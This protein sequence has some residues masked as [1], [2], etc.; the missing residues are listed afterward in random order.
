MPPAAQDV[1]FDPRSTALDWRVATGLLLLGNVVGLILTHRMAIS[2]ALARSATPSFFKTLWFKVGFPVLDTTSAVATSTANH[3]AHLRDNPVWEW[4]HSQWQSRGHNIV[5][6]GSPPIIELEPVKV[7]L[8]F[9]PDAQISSFPWTSVDLQHPTQ[10]ILTYGLPSVVTNAAVSPTVGPTPSSTAYAFNDDDVDLEFGSAA[11]RLGD[12]LKGFLLMCA[13][14]VRSLRNKA[15]RSFRVGRGATVFEYGELT[16]GF[17]LLHSSTTLPF[18]LTLLRVIYA[19]S[20]RIVAQILLPILEPFVRYLRAVLEPPAPPAR[21]VVAPNLPVAAPVSPPALATTQPVPTPVPSQT[22]TPEVAIEPS[23]HASKDRTA[24]INSFK[25]NKIER[26]MSEPT[27]FR[28]EL[29]EAPRPSSTSF[30][31]LAASPKSPPAPLIALL[32]AREQAEEKALA[33]DTPLPSSSTL[34]M[35]ET[36]PPPAKSRYDFTLSHVSLNTFTLG[37]PPAPKAKRPS[38]S[39][40]ACHTSDSEPGATTSPTREASSSTPS[41]TAPGETV[42]A[43]A[44]VAPP[45]SPYVPWDKR[46]SNQKMRDDIPPWFMAPHPDSAQL[47]AVRGNSMSGDLYF[48]ACLWNDAEP[49]EMIDPN[50]RPTA[51]RQKKGRSAPLTQNKDSKPEPS[52]SRSKKGFTFDPSL[53]SVPAPPINSKADVPKERAKVPEIKPFDFRVPVSSDFLAAPPQQYTRARSDLPFRF[54]SPS[55]LAPQV[56]HSN[57]EGETITSS[58]SSPAPDILSSSPPFAFDSVSPRPTQSGIRRAPGGGPDLST[59]GVPSRECFEF[60]GVHQDS[61]NACDETASGDA[62]S[63]QGPFV[64]IR[65]LWQLE[66]GDDV[67]DNFTFD[68]GDFSFPSTPIDFGGPEQSD[69][70]PQA[71]GDRSQPAREDIGFSSDLMT[72][73]VNR[74]F[75]EQ[76]FVSEVIV[77]RIQLLLVR[78]NATIGFLGDRCDSAR[79]WDSLPKDLWDEFYEV[80]DAAHRISV[81]LSVFYQHGNVEI[82]MV[83]MN[84]RPSHVP[85]PPLSPVTER[86]P[87]QPGPQSSGTGSVDCRTTDE[88]EQRSASDPRIL[89]LEV[90]NPFYMAESAP[91]EIK[92]PDGTYEERPSHFKIVLSPITSTFPVEHGENIPPSPSKIAAEGSSQPKSGSAV[93]KMPSTPLQTQGSLEEELVTPENTK[94]DDPVSIRHSPPDVDA[95]CSPSPAVSRDLAFLLNTSKESLST[96]VPSAPPLEPFFSP[97]RLL[98]PS[99]TSHSTSPINRKNIECPHA[100]DDSCISLA[101]SPTVTPRPRSAS[102]GATHIS[103]APEPVAPACHAPSNDNCETAPV[104]AVHDDTAL[105]DVQLEDDDELDEVEQMLA[106]LSIVSPVVSSPGEKAHPASLLPSFP[107]PPKTAVPPASKH[108]SPRYASAKSAIQAIISPTKSKFTFAQSAGEIEPPATAVH[109]GKSASVDDGSPTSPCHCSI[110]ERAGSSESRQDE[111]E[112]PGRSY[113]VPMYFDWPEASASASSSSSRAHPASSDNVPFK[114]FDSSSS[115]VNT[116]GA[117]QFGDVPGASET[118]KLHGWSD[119]E[120]KEVKP[121]G[122][123]KGKEGADKWSHTSQPTGPRVTQPRMWAGPILSAKPKRDAPDSDLSMTE[124]K[125]SSTDW[126]ARINS[127]KTQAKPRSGSEAAKSS[128]TH[129]PHPQ[130]FSKPRVSAASPPSSATPAPAKPDDPRTSPSSTATRKT[131]ASAAN[132]IGSIPDWAS[133]PP[134]QSR[135]QGWTTVG[136]KSRSKR[137]R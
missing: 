126:L 135:N 67:P 134:V 16:R 57:S 64:E 128:S 103:S 35:I 104:I 132:A 110:C 7:I 88:D 4:L 123:G 46:G 105:S 84:K 106:G 108:T 28:D 1:G 23:S 22:H 60:L 8:E 21:V 89:V 32:N 11:S 109:Q 9:I 41:D 70:A 115:N 73:M 36:Y 97:H 98:H 92:L 62:S 112:D 85:P 117:A 29:R 125:G 31:D 14:I 95:D 101:R 74:S 102:V 52:I 124:L 122:K 53:F 137:R 19:A 58:F 113:F 61:P 15:K 71:V 55:Q 65:E 54:D 114:V 77:E 91:I 119:S 18:L 75:E 129:I 49:A 43:P 87:V 12:Y 83:S 34:P 27:L 17:S 130:S 111:L 37:A 100:S 44:Y 13:A 40:N 127:F 48:G 121:I 26:T 94:R 68:L 93:R 96:S 80:Y 120:E 10:V 45:I 3:V 59:S 82:D 47:P 66:Q 133:R 76:Q 78:M 131:Y 63:A 72:P 79:P 24:L 5:H 56:S 81:L 39:H 86:D 90:R 2:E 30:L 38:P 107:H 69:T 42:S 99:L 33:L 136:A 6:V 116:E 20:L 25:Q 50:P 51:S 118:R